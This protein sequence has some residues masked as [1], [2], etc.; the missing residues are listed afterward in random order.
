[1]VWA[2]IIAGVVSGVCNT[3]LIA[4]IN[5]VLSKAGAPTTSLVW[6][7]AGLC[8]TLALT[9]FISGALLVGLMQRA[10]FGLRMRLCGQILKA[11]LHH[12][13]RLGTHRLLVTLTD[14]V[15]T[16]TSA[17]VTLPLLCMNV[18]IIVG[19]LAYLCWLSWF[20]LVGVLCFMLLGVVSHQIPVA[21][22]SKYFARAREEMDVVFKHFRGLTEGIKEL[23]LHRG[24][25]ETFFSTLLRPRVQSMQREAARG[26]I[27]WTA[28]GSWGQILFFVFIGIVLFVVPV[29][30]P[31][32]AGVLTGYTL[33]ILYLMGPLEYILNTLPRLS[34]ADIAVKKIEALSSSLA[35]QTLDEAASPAGTGQSWQL[36]ELEGLTHSYRREGEETE[37]TMGPLDLRVRPGELIFITG[38]NGSGKTTLAKLLVGLYVPQS[39]RIFLD[40]EPVTDENRDDYR[41]LFSVVFSDY[42]LFDSL[43]GEGGTDADAK[44]KEYLARLQLDRHV[45]VEGGKF[46]TV[47]LS[48]GQRKRL[49]L[50]TAYL[51]NRP[52]YVFDEWAADQD[53]QFKEIFYLQLLA[54]LKAA[55]KTVLVITH[56]D[57]YYHVA[58]RVVKLNYGCVEYDRR[59]GRSVT[60][61]P[62]EDRSELI[63]TQT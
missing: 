10:M 22:A 52:I 20:L 46:S 18:A 42:Y 55:G 9:R 29:L 25:R 53:P 13:E 63:T 14:D 19:C 23:K 16:I 54:G 12:L 24:W 5:S 2:V 44:A 3:L 26:E 48:Q 62:A 17:L 4:V 61:G 39:G 30:R 27:I 21:R 31:T 40:G 49:A 28:A 41:Q 1:M 35:E 36:L 51:D 6:S 45:R 7:F 43:L 57:R 38:G 59:V 34:L 8:L 33:T 11:P 37:F 56:D 58:D 32:S 60:D 50:L 47:E 15:P